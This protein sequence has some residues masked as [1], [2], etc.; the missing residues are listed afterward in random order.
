MKNNLHFTIPARYYCRGTPDWESPFPAKGYQGEKEKAITLDA[1]TTAITCGHLDN[2]GYPGGGR[3][4]GEPGVEVFYREWRQ[5]E[6]FVVN[7]RIAPLVNRARAGGISILYLVNGWAS[8]KKYPQYREIASRVKTPSANWSLPPHPHRDEI[9]QWKEEKEEEYLGK[10]FRE[11]FGEEKSWD[12]APP[13]SAHCEDWIVTSGSQSSTLFKEKGIWNIFFLGFE[14]A[15]CLL[16]LSGGLLD[17]SR[18][19]Y[20]CFLVEDCSLCL[21]TRKTRAQEEIKRAFFQ[22]MQLYGYA[23]LV[24]SEEIIAGLKRAE[25]GRSDERKNS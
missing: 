6:Q 13:V 19:G 24:K 2:E 9:E 7:E 14:G 25:K 10:D 5:R 23:Y 22:S 11:E 12:I 20:R 17:M 4:R 1:S 18:R 8:S 3:Y 15:S 21:E 16:N